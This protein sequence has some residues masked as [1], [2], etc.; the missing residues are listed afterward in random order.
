MKNRKRRISSST[1]ES[2]SHSLRSSFFAAVVCYRLLLSSYVIDVH[3]A[4]F[5]SVLIAE[6]RKIEQKKT[7]TT[8]LPNHTKQYPQRERAHIRQ[9]EYYT[10]KYIHICTSILLKPPRTNEQPTKTR[11]RVF[12]SLSFLFQSLLL[13]FAQKQQL[14][15]NDELMRVLCPRSAALFCFAALS[16]AIYMK[17][18]EKNTIR[19]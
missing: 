19:T 7:Y 6:N 11:I 3:L 5:G 14:R 1:T 9:S 8:T 13:V 2:L 15:Y 4:P 16:I 17:R 10:V 12:V 18:R